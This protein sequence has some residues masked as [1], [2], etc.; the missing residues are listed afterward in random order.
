MRTL[1]LMARGDKQ[2]PGNDIIFDGF[3]KVVSDL[4]LIF[5]VIREDKALTDIA[6]KWGR[7]I[8]SM[9]NLIDNDPIPDDGVE[10][11]LSKL[12]MMSAEIGIASVLNDK[13]M[14]FLG[15]KEH[16]ELLRRA[17]KAWFLP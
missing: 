4:H 7:N 9:R 11:V 14:I 1:T 16:I 12:D 6:N 10:S 3:T 15:I 13:G 5:Y 17:V 2:L 8:L